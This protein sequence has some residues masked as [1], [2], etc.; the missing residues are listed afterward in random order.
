MSVLRIRN[1][2]LTIT[3]E[4]VANNSAPSKYRTSLQFDTMGL[5]AFYQCVQKCVH[6]YDDDEIE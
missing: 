4:T 2:I 5:R 6:Q 1:S 3:F